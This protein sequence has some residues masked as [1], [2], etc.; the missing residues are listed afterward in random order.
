MENFIL[1]DHAPSLLPSGKKWKLVWHDEFDGTELDTSKWGFRRNFWGR[2]FPAFTDQGV[3]L[4]GKSHL[5]LHVT[6]R[7]GEYCSHIFKQPP[8]PMTFPKTAVVSGR[9]ASMNN[10]SS[11]INSGITRFVAVSTDNPA[12]G[13]HSGFSHLPSEH[14]RTLLNAEWNVISWKAR[15]IRRKKRSAAVI[16]GMVMEPTIKVPATKFTNWQIPV[17]DGTVSVLTGM[18]P[19]MFFIRMAKR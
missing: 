3:I 4:D 14:I 12:G 9:S 5:Q 6:E 2:K 10:R 11:C 17:T 13:L 1:E 16:S 15:I 7:N 19:D 8:L 18:H